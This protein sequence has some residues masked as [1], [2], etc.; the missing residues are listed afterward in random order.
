MS[1]EPIIQ[2]QPID[3]N[4]IFMAILCFA[5]FYMWNQ[6]EDG[7]EKNSTANTQITQLQGQI[8]YLSEG[9]ERTTRVIDRLDEKLDD[10]TRSPRFTQENF[11]RSV[12]P[13]VRQQ[14]DLATEVSRQAARFGDI[15][16]RVSSIE[17]GN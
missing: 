13:I 15:E 14:N 1:Q 5:A 10:F 11:D 12:A 4:R 9:L 16:S 2:S 17:R 3:I 6:Q 7:R 8:T